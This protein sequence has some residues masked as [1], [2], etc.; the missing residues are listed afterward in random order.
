MIAR[1]LWAGLLLVALAGCSKYMDGYSCLHP[2]RG[3]KDA[4]N[5]PDPCHENDPDAGEDAGA[6]PSCE[7]GEYAHWR[8][9][10]EGPTLLWIGPEDQAPECPRGPTT[11]SYEGHAD[12]AAPSLCEGCT[13]EPPT[14]S[15]A[16]PSTLTASTAVCYAP[17]A[18]TSFN[19]PTPW[20]GSCDGAIQTPDGAA[21]SLTIDPIIM[22]ENGCASGPTVAAKVISLH[23]DTFA[24]GCDVGLPLGP[25]E[26]SACLPADPI[27]PGFKACIFFNDEIDCPNDEP[28]NLFTEQHVFYQGVQDDRQCSAC[29]CGAPTGGACTATLSIYKGADLTC[30]GPT[31]AKEIT[32]S[33][34]GP[35]C[36]D[37]QLP[38]Q[39]LGSKSAGSTTYLPGMCPPEGGVSSG[40]AIPTHPA[41]LC[42]RP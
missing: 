28:G 26:R 6:E 39:A 34:E 7:V 29:T 8:L 4:D 11:L 36:L 30:S 2:D 23:W 18:T 13:C 38:G 32:I 20:D 9:P 25:V 21:H 14:G 42:C 27:V 19:A 16:L 31:V 12:L 41:T 24:R 3:H 40:A 22:T 5:N 17:G 10:W 15:C 1:S 35:T 33:S 37:I